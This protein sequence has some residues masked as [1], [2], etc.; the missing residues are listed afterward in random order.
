MCMCVHVC[1]C[2]RV[3]VCVRVCVLF[4]VTY[5]HRLVGHRVPIVNILDVTRV[6]VS[7]STVCCIRTGEGSRIDMLIV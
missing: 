5:A 2:A 6:F 3:C 4:G 7:S 1:V